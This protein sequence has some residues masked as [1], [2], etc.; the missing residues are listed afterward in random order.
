MSNSDRKYS[1]AAVTGFIL[2][3]APVAIFFIIEFADL[4]IHIHSW[5]F[6]KIYAYSIIVCGILSILIGSILSIA[7]LI[8]CSRK[9]LKG[10]GLA[11]TALVF[12]VLEAMIAIVALAVA[13]KAYLAVI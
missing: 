1:K 10:K 12:F 6:N 5:G 2:A 11:I 7:G 4:F 3:V 13:A 8:A 9:D